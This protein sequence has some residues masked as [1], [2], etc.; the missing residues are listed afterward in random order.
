VKAELIQ[1][2]DNQ[3]VRFLVVGG[4]SAALNFLSRIYF[5]NYVEF[6]FAVV[7]AFFVGLTTAF[8]LSKNYVFPKGKRSFV[9]S[10]SYFL[11][12]NVIA[13]ALVWGSS[14]AMLHVVLPALHVVN[15]AE[16]IAHAVGICLPV[17]TSYIAHKYITFA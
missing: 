3:F 2:K 15:N 1:L 14:L 5:S 17:I 7:L 10:F 9:A 6:S 12:I 4:F 13:L 16:E 11:I 8:M